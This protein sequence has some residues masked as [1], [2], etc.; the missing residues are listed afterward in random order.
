[1]VKALL[2]QNL[3]N[4]GKENRHYKCDS[5]INSPRSRTHVKGNRPKLLLMNIVVGCF[6][7]SN[8][9]FLKKKSVLAINLESFRPMIG[10]DWI[11]NNS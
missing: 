6:H 8:L 2:I 5:S 1:M 9:I 3:K 10:Q 4:H 11:H 7:Q